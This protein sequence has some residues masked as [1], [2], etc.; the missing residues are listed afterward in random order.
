MFLG[1]DRYISSFGYLVAISVFLSFAFC[2]SAEERTPLVIGNSNYQNVD[3][4]RNP[5][6]DAKDLAASLENKGFKVTRLNNGTLD[7]MRSALRNFGESAQKFD[8][9]M[10]FFAGHGIEIG[11]VNWLIPID[12]RLELDRR[13]PD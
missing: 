1:I 8:L 3:Y 9:V 13:K 2:V 11:G 12:A 5:E 10:V 6:N 7:D 4:L